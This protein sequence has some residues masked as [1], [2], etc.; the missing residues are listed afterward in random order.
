MTY[1]KKRIILY[2]YVNKMIDKILSHLECDQSIS[3]ICSKVNSFLLYHNWKKISY[4]FEF[5][6][7]TKRNSMSVK[8]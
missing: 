6:Y 5:L 7:N 1:I 2:F 3:N 8:N 4:L